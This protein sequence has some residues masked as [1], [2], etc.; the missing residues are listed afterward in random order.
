MID[1]N[2]PRPTFD[3]VTA[4]L[5]AILLGQPFVV[6]VIQICHRD[7]WILTDGEQGI[8]V[9]T[10]EHGHGVVD[11]EYRVNDTTYQGADRRSLKDPRYANAMVGGH[12]VVHF[13]ASHPWLSSIDLPATTF[14]AGWP[15]IMFIWFVEARLITTIVK[16][17]SKWALKMRGKNAFSLRTIPA[18]PSRNRT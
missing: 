13:S 9:V 7:Y 5:V 14:P 1:A 4:L 12:T 17:G 11:Y 15:L 18:T 2:Q 3:R 8:G 16:P 6:D 10:L